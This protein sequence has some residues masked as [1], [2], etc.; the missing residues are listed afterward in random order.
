MVEDKYFGSF[1]S[2]LF[3]ISTPI[4]HAKDIS[5]RA[6]EHFKSASRVYCED[7]RVFRDLAKRIDLDISHLKIE[8][9]HDHSNDALVDKIINFAKEEICLFVSDAGSPVISDPAFPLIR[10][11]IEEGVNFDSIGGVCSPVLALE[12]SGLAPTPFHFHGFLGRDKGARAK[13]FE[14]FGQVYGTHIFFEGVSRVLKCLEHLCDTFPEKDIVVARELTKDYQS[15][16]RF[17][18]DE[19]AKIKSEIVEKGEFIILI[20]NEDKMNFTQFAEQQSIA[21]EILKKGM[22]PKLVA[23]LLSSI[24]GENS[25]EIYQQLNQS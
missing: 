10:R 9:Y 4:G 7:T 15:V 24:T 5:L 20:H 16:Y 25:K 12:L 13:D 22:R 2:G 23:K 21:Q 11:A 8:S 19:F 3:L 14:T 1:M 17:K 6:L 18:G